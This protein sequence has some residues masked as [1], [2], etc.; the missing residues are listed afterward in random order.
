MTSNA[1][2]PR[3]CVVGSFMMDLTVRASRRPASG[4]TLQGTSFQ[5]SLGGKGFNQAVAARR[6]G[7]DVSFVG[8]VGTDEFGDR[9]LEGLSHE[10]IDAT[11][12]IRRPGTGT[13]VGL[14]LVEDGGQNSIVIVPRANLE[15]SAADVAT[16]RDAIE[17]SDILL[18][19]L[20]LDPSTALAAA[21]IAHAAGRTVILNPAPFAPLDPELLA[22]VDVLVPNEG[23]ARSLAGRGPFDNALPADPDGSVGPDAF[24]RDS[25]DVVPFLRR[26]FHGDL[27]IT[28]GSDGVLVAPSSGEDPVHLPAVEAPVVDTVGAGDVFCGVL[29]TGIAGGLPLVEA[30]RR[31][32]A[33]A[34]LA[35]GNPGGADAAPT[36]EQ[37]EALESRSPS[38]SAPD[39]R[40]PSN[41]GLTF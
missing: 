3:I 41:S 15:L 6:A 2:T 21:R 26:D 18:L 24:P 12:V 9:F 37:I 33:A 8:M 16:A 23:E 20:E 1:G 10:G 29:G 34:A 7:A 14:P 22:T 25:A 30:A 35:V 40:V 32:N 27:V 39:D 36:R 11:H 19:Q 28:L 38:P 31:A 13:G 5:V 4:E 17:S